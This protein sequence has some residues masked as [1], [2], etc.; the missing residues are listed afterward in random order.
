MLTK[1]VN[2]RNVSCVN[3]VG[4]RLKSAREG[5][6]LSLREFAKELDE[7]FTLLSRIER[8]E[9]Y[10]PKP[11]LKRFAKALSL[12]P[13]QLG[14]LIS[15]E[16]R[17]LNPHELL[18]EIPPAHISNHSIEAAAETVLKKYCRA[19]GKNDV[20][21]PVPVEG[22]LKE[23]CKLLTERRNFEKKSI[24]GAPK[25]LCGCLYPEGFEG[26]DRIVLINTGRIRGRQP[27]IEEQRTTIAH[28]AGHY[29]LHYGDKESAQ[30]FFRFSKGP[31]F[32]REPECE[33]TLFNPLEYQASAFAACLLM[34]RKQFVAEWE[35]P[36]RIEAKIA[37]LFGVTDSFVRFRAKMLG[38]E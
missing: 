34:P 5:R 16:R 29:V 20:E 12:T 15:V 3:V 2:R 19:V 26:K 13:Q 18:P 4:Q 27:T 36:T 10:P 11:R 1:N 24:P 37:Q 6:G 28:E 35:K 9:R 31:T 32:C 33:D 30:L 8:G 25:L 7:D 38:C 14:A 21:L 17:G 23:A 22:V